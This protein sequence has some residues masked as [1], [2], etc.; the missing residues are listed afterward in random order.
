MRERLNQLILNTQGQFIEV[1]DRSNIYQCKDLIYLWVFCLGFPKSTVQGLYAYTM[2][3]SPNASTREYFDIIPNTPDFIPQDGDIAVFDKTATN[4]AGHTG[5]CLGGGTTGKFMSFEQNYPIGTNA[6]VR[7]R[8]YLTPKLLG[9]LRPKVNKLDFVITDQTTLPIIDSSGN[10]MELQ[11][12][13]STIADQERKITNLLSEIDALN[14]KISQLQE[15]LTDTPQITSGNA[16]SDSTMTSTA[17]L[18]LFQKIM[19]WIKK[20]LG[21][22]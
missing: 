21:I 20:L 3:T 13:R 8:N 17:T 4:P 22:W 11:A 16:I 14:V 15:K 1:S 2:Y 6:S 19:E 12:V 5:I 9:V 18:S 10:K 7:E